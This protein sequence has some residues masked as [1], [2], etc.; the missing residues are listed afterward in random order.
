MTTDRIIKP[1]WERR[2]LI[3]TSTLTVTIATFC[4]F[5][6]L[7]YAYQ[8]SVVLVATSKDGRSIPPGQVPRLY[9][10][11][12]SAPVFNQLMQSEPF[13]D[14]R[15]SGATTEVL[16]ERLSSNTGIREDVQGSSVI[17]HLTYLDFTPEAA[18]K[19][20]NVLGQGIAS[21]ELGTESENGF[22]FKVLQPASPAT[23]PIKPR[24]FMLTMFALGG[25]LLLGFVLAAVSELFKNRRHV[26]FDSPSVRAT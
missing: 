10:E 3:L 18:E 25:G 14:Q 6:R 8:S 11:L 22:A 12:K 2:W 15:E 4:W 16:V 7:P 21:A 19:G 24:R 5:Q 1:F 23:G 9:K 13:K 26:K 17:V 20:A